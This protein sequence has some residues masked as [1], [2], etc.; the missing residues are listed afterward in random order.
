MRASMVKSTKSVPKQSEKQS[1][2]KQ[3]MSRFT[4]DLSTDLHKKFKMLAAYRGELMGDVLRTYI[5]SYVKKH[6]TELL[7]K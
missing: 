4:F 7:E 6:L 5:D 2:E 1:Q 3:E